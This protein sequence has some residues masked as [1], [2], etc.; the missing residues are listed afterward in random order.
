MITYSVWIFLWRTWIRKFVRSKVS[1]I[2]SSSRY[3]WVQEVQ[4]KNLKIHDYFY[5]QWCKGS[6]RPFPE[7][8]ENK[9]VNILVQTKAVKFVRFKDISLN[10]WQISTRELQTLYFKGRNFWRIS[11]IAISITKLNPFERAFFS[12][13]RNKI[14]AKKLLITDKILFWKICFLAE[15]TSIKIVA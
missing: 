3:N 6:E 10:V 11:Q 5:P 4:R 14:P 8:N 9:L 2:V 1:R 12:D 7:V 13:S 15:S